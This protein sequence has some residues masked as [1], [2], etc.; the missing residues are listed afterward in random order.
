MPTSPAWCFGWL[1][2]ANLQCLRITTTHW[3][4]QP[5]V[6]QTPKCF[7]ATLTYASKIGKLIGCSGIVMTLGTSVAIDA[8]GVSWPYGFAACGFQI[9]A[10]IILLCWNQID[11]GAKMAAYCKS[12]MSFRD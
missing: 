10:S 6:R 2:L 11:T 1:H 9:I 7:L 12:S 3:A 5:S 4:L 8:T